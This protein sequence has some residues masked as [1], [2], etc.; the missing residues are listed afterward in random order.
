MASEEVE[1]CCPCK[2]SFCDCHRHVPGSDEDNVNNAGLV[3]GVED[4]AIFIVESRL[5]LGSILLTPS[6][7]LTIY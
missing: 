5:V 2:G 6:Y 3:T 1:I 7:S 4:G